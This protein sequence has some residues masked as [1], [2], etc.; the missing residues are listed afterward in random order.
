MPTCS[1]GF[2]FHCRFT[3]VGAFPAD[4]QQGSSSVKNPAGA[5]RT[6]DIEVTGNLFFQHTQLNIRPAACTK[7]GKNFFIRKN[8]V[9]HTFREPCRQ[10]SSSHGYRFKM[11]DTP[12]IRDLPGKDL[13]TPDC[14]VVA[15]SYPID[16]NTDAG[17][18]SC[19]G[20]MRTV[21]LHGNKFKTV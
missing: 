9:E 18:C 5:G 1:R 2:E 4:P 14:P 7:Q 13:T 12:E 3:I 8:P 20:N 10:I 16:S 15:I 17:L 6:G 19:R 11:G 21:V